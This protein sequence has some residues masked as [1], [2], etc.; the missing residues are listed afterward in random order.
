MGIFLH[1]LVVGHA[2][3]DHRAGDEVLQFVLITLVEG[4]ELGVDVYD[5]IL[6]DIGERVLLL[7][8][9]LSRI[10]VTAQGRRT[11]QVQECGLE[12]SPARLS[13]RVR[14]GYGTHGRPWHWRPLPRATCRRCARLRKLPVQEW[15]SVKRKN[16]CSNSLMASF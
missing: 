1:I 9:Y 13:V 12:L 3:F 8:I 4:F 2:V 11:E 10:A 14:C 6:A 5:E 16:Y 7:R 15:L